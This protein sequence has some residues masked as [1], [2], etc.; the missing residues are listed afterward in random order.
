MSGCPQCAELRA[1]VEQLERELRGRRRTILNL[2]RNLAEARGETANSD[3]Y[4]PLV[5]ELFDYWRRTCGHER[6]KLDGKRYRA[7]RA[8]LV[9]GSSPAEIRE[10][11][12]GAAAAPNRHDRTGE[13]YDDLELICRNQA[14]LDSFRKRAPK[15]DGAGEV[16][17][18]L[19]GA[20][21]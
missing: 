5:H 16:M 14:K 2:Q 7:V 11:I 19:I 20:S 13:P 12:D 18:K 15:V 10:A 1:E 17:R 9:E 8:R 3:E 21:E 4:A 6:A